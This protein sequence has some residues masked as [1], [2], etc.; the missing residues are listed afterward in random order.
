V[1]AGAEPFDLPADGDA[2]AAVLLCHGFTGSP[3][4]MRPWGEH[5]AAA[6]FPVACPLLPGHG[7][8]WRD[9]NATT[10]RDWYA[11]VD[12]AYAELAGRYPM[13]FAMGLSMGG[14]LSLRLAER[15]P[16]LAGLV[17]VNPSLTTERW[18]ARL[19]LPLIGRVLPSWSPIGGDIR[20][21]GVTEVAYDRTPL[22]A[23]LSLREF[24]GV[25]RADLARVTQPVLLYRGAHDHTVEPVNAQVVR[26]GVRGEYTEKVLPD[27]AHVATLDNDAE[28]I[29]SGSVEF[30]RRIVGAVPDAR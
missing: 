1:L 13:V 16:G 27:S 11:A 2:G 15:H 30:A 19:L 4:S 5:L 21:P 3:Q 26:E 9:A 22:K 14:A 7:T 24:W 12:T 6:G 23:M 28:M 17:L 29:F 20:K 8:H 18:D 10:W 25:V